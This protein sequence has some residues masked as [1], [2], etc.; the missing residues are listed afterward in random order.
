[1]KYSVISILI[2]LFYSCSNNNKLK[3]VVYPEYCQGCIIRNFMQIKKD[4]T[5]DKFQIYLDTSDQFLF[6]FIKNNGFKIHHIK[7]E[8]IKFQFGDYCNILF[9]NKEGRKF[10]LKTNETLKKGKNY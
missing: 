4:N 7:K 1:M 8:D 9:I 6:S 3:L 2:V 10:E 5:K